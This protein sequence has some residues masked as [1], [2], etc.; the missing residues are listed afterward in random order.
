MGSTLKPGGK[1]GYIDPFKTV[2][3]TGAY[4]LGPILQSF[5]V[6]TTG[7]NPGMFVDQGA[8][9]VGTEEQCTVGANASVAAIGIAE[10]DFGMLAS[11]A[12]AYVATDS[13]PI[14]MFHWNWGALLRNIKTVTPGADKGPGAFCGTTSGTAGKWIQGTLTTGANIRAQDFVLNGA[15]ADIVAWIENYSP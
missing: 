9:T 15:V 3:I 12:A 1:R 5:E 8:A 13:A 10:V 2:F 4:N 7:F 11:C 14:L 6:I